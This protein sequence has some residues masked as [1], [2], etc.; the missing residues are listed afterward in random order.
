[1]NDLRLYRRVNWIDVFIVVIAAF[2]VVIGLIVRAKDAP[3]APQSAVAIAAEAS[4]V[5]SLENLR[6]R[7]DEPLFSLD[8]VTVNGRPVAANAV[9]E[10]PVQSRDSVSVSGWA[11]DRVDGVPANAI[12]VAVGSEKPLLLQNGGDRP[13]VAQALGNPKLEKT[14]FSGK[15]SL[16]SLTA[17]TLPLTFFVVDRAGLTYDAVPISVSLAVK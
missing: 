5:A 7:R 16:S 13:D 1:M 4:P 9:K 10:I 6:L 2:A 12:F 17:G 11:A 15:L 14:G 3:F 8:T